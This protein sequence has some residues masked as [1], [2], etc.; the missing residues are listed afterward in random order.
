[1]RAAFFRRSRIA[2]A[3]P[4]GLGDWSDKDGAAPVVEVPEAGVKAL[5]EDFGCMPWAP[6]ENMVCA[7]SVPS[8]W[9]QD[10]DNFGVGGLGLDNGSEGLLQGY[11]GARG[12]LL[13]CVYE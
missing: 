13:H 2:S 6:V 3:M 1:M 10:S 5:R 7:K 8:V 9:E 4:W 12:G 11:G